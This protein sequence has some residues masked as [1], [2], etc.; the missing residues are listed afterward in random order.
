MKQ[1]PHEIIQEIA[2]HLGSG[3][4]A[5]LHTETLEVVTY[6]DEDKSLSFE[7]SMWKQEMD[8][9]RKQRHKFFEVRGMEPHDS[10]RVMEDFIATVNDKHLQERLS[11]ALLQQKPC[12][13]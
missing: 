6:P 2:S 4:R 5:F 8:T 3:F 11:K 10:F 9:V 7:P 13:L 1:I 12:S